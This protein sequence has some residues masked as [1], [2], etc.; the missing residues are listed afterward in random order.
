MGA[1]KA[2]IDYL[3]RVKCQFYGRMHYPG[4]VYEFVS[5]LQV[6][7]KHFDKLG[8]HVAKVSIE[9]QISELRE[10]VIKLEE[11][12]VV[13][14]AKAKSRAKGKAKVTAKVETEAEEVKDEEIS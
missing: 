1:S 8:P 11:G 14:K 5:T 10:R 7:E 4:Q 9:A 3:C 6:P 13:V 12:K 2:A